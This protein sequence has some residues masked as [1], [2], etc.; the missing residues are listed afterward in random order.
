LDKDLERKGPHDLEQGPASIILQEGEEVF[1]PNPSYRNEWGGGL[2]KYICFQ[3]GNGRVSCRK[4]GG[5]G[6]RTQP[7]AMSTEA[8]GEEQKENHL[9]EGFGGERIGELQINSR[10]GGNWEEVGRAARTG[11][12]KPTK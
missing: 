11:G 6:G 1:V 9:D 10:T 2:K 12:K 4:R 5:K 8:G 3:P 7:L